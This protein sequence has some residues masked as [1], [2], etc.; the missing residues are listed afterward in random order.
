MSGTVGRFS[1]A[2][3]RGCREGRGGCGCVRM[4]QDRRT[5]DCLSE[6][7]WRFGCVRV[8]CVRVRC[9]HFSLQSQGKRVA[10][11]FCG[12]CG[13]SGSF[14]A[15]C[16]G[17]RRGD[18]SGSD[19]VRW[20]WLS[21]DDETANMRIIGGERRVEVRQAKYCTRNEASALLG[22]GETH[23]PH[24]GGQWAVGVWRWRCV[25]NTSRLTIQKEV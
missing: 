4:L 6:G 13:L 14:F 11:T 24:Q 1:M 15:A 17:G 8:R 2:R 7:S 23:D 5:G 19:Q 21:S 18:D 25:S 3:R 12:G 20:M 22:N 10:H 9:H 16:D